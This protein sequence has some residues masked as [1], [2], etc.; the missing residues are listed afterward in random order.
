MSTT[1][2]S[3]QTQTPN[4]EEELKE[5]LA[6]KVL[7]YIRDNESLI[8]LNKITHEVLNAYFL[9]PEAL[10]E[11]TVKFVM[12][13]RHNELIKN[14]EFDPYRETLQNK[15]Y[16]YTVE[17][18]QIV[19]VRMSTAKVIASIYLPNNELIGDIIIWYDDVKMKYKEAQN[20]M[21]EVE[22]LVKQMMEQIR[23]LD[24]KISELKKKL[25]ECE[26]KEKEEEGEEEE[27]D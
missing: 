6:Q 27:K 7:Q 1:Q 22:K 21:K 15:L 23:K 5:K 9:D 11:E 24:E 8:L 10:V 25:E 12:A 19:D 4:L 18:A 16:N 20:E 3:N 2:T 13:I 26:N 14:I 17:E